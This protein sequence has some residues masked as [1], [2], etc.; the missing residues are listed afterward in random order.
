V[1][2]LD[3][4]LTSFALSLFHALE[5]NTQTKTRVLVV[6]CGMLATI[7]QWLVHLS[8]PYTFH[9]LLQTESKILFLFG[10]AFVLAP[11]FAVAFLYRLLHLPPSQ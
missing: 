5:A 2:S 9:N 7:G 11:P 3:R 8:Y 4:R 6:G 1:S 10:F